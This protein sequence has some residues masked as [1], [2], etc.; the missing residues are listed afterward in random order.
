MDDAEQA[1]LE[2]LF[3][4]VDDEPEPPTV[5]LSRLKKEPNLAVRLPEPGPVTVRR[6]DGTSETRPM[7]PAELAAWYKEEAKYVG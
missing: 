7:N 5:V 1:L 4:M 2:Q 3:G 6:S